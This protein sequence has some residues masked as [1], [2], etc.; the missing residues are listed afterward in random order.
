MAALNIQLSKQYWYA[1]MQHTF[2]RYSCR[3]GTQI[4]STHESCLQ[5]LAYFFPEEGG[6]ED[7]PGVHGLHFVPNFAT[8][9]LRL[10]CILLPIFWMS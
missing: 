6:E 3:C 8:A 7:P 9:A 5:P 1:N 10:V 2:K 4:C